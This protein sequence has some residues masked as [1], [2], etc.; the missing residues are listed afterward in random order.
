MK[1]YSKGLFI[2]R[3]DLRI[4]DNVW[5]FEAI[6]NCEQIIPL[7]IFDTTVLSKFPKDDKRLWFQREALEYLEKSIQNIW[8]TFYVEYGDPEIIVPFILDEFA[9]DAVYCNRSYG[10][11]S[12]SRDRSIKQL[13]EVRNIDYFACTDYLLL[14]VD[15]VEVRKVFTPFFKKRL[16]LVQHEQLNWSTN[17]TPLTCNSPRINLPTLQS[18]KNNIPCHSHEIWKIWWIRERLSSIK[19]TDYDNT[20]NIPSNTE[21]TTKLS[22][23]LAFWVISPREVWRHFVKHMSVEQWFPQDKNRA[24]IIVSELAWREFWQHISYH[25]PETTYWDYLEFQEKRRTIVWENNVDRFEKRKNWTTWYPIIDAWM[26][27]LKYE[28]RMHNR[29]RMVVASFLTKDLLVDWR[30]WEK[31][32]ANYL[33]DYDRNVNIGNW[34]WSA[35]VW[36]DPKPL[37]IFNPIL[38]SK[39]HDVLASYILKRVPELEW[40]PIPAI[41]DPIKY[42]LDYHPPLMNHYEWSKEAKVR[43]NFAK[44]E[45]QKWI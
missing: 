39:K 12:T 18:H 8:G 14:E 9:I 21:W 24:D 19:L 38:Q 33:V 3:Q 22:P 20:R 26:R 28:N 16:P 25:F 31:H 29:V 37:R 10:F 44:E 2:F 23:Y 41:H 17:K 27:Q 45:Y 11:W 13:C 34:Q 15:V 42:R 4:V 1:K 35:S 7:F 30:W 6:K 32:F 36:A 5:F 43:Y 40:Q